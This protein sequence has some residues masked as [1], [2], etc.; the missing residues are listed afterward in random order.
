MN[1]SYRSEA[2]NLAPERNTGQNTGPTILFEQ[3]QRL[4]LLAAAGIVGQVILLAS[5][6]LLPL[7]SE[8]D[9]PRDTV[10]E[11]ALGSYGFIQTAA[12]VLSGLGVLGLAYAIRRLTTGAWGSLAGSLLLAVYGLGAIL[13]AFFP[14]DAV[15]SASDLAALTTT[16][17]IHSGVALVSFASATAGMVVLAWTFS[18]EPRWRSL[19]PWAAI[20]ATAAVS[21]MIGQAVEPQGPWTGLLQ[22]MLVTVIAAWLVAA[23]LRVRRIASPEL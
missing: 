5:A 14:T 9:I 19:T 7:V 22:R 12:F 6:W 23:A 2:P 18:R 1:G 15:D 21:L 10:S 20:F 8:Y 16:G 11:L 13:V 3:A 17:M 4:S